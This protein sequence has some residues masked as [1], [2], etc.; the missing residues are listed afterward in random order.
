MTKHHRRNS[1]QES[2]Y[3]YGLGF[4]SI[5]GNDNCTSS[6]PDTENGLDSTDKLNLDMMMDVPGSINSF[7]LSSEDDYVYSD[8]DNSLQDFGKDQ[9][10][11]N[12][13]MNDEIEVCLI[14][15]SMNYDSEN[16]NDTLGRT[17]TS[18]SESSVES[19]RLDKKRRF[20]KLSSSSSSSLSSMTEREHNDLV[21]ILFKNGFCRKES[22]SQND[23]P[24]ETLGAI[25][26]TCTRTVWDM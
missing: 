24:R 18:N 26:R 15:T 22:Q 19:P 14:D 7:D 8:D 12:S 20:S 5:G 16:D 3:L 21:T 10:D 9:D 4:L 1:S 17:P 6:S 13:S 23:E 2:F 25:R 11:T